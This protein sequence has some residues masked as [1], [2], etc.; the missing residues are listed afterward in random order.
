MKKSVQE[1]PLKP[2]RLK[3]QKLETPDLILQ[4]N[5]VQKG[6]IDNIIGKMLGFLVIS[7]LF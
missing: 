2:P 7:H 5:S 6:W 4:K 1:S 3:I